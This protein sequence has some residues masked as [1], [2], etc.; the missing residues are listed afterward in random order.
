MIKTIAYMVIYRRSKMEPKVEETF[1]TAEAAYHFALD[2]ETNGGVTIVTPI[3]R[4]VT[5]NKV[6]LN[7]ED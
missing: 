6:K 4:F 5:E 7:F 3:E 2:I 1:V